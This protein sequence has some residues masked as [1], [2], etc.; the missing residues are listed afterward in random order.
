MTLS[1]MLLPV[2]LR[3]GCGSFIPNREE[4]SDLPA[5]ISPNGYRRAGL[6]TS[7]RFLARS[8]CHGG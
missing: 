8:L 1:I 6:A 4:D 3:R 7:R 2:R 5:S